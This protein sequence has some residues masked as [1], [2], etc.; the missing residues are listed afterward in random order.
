MSEDKFQKETYQTIV[1]TAQKLFMELGYRSVSTRQIAQTC[2]I[3]QPAL[4]HHFKNK[5][6]LY[7]AVLKHTLLET[8]MGLRAILSQYHSFYDR[9]CHISIYMMLQFEVDM[10]QMFHDINHELSLDEQKEIHQYWKNGFLM[11]VVNMIQ[12]GMENGEIKDSSIIGSSPI[13]LAFLI[14]NIIKSV[15]QAPNFSKLPPEE[16]RKT[17]EKNAQLIVEIF[18]NGMKA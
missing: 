8:E 16:Q 2:G 7:I 10:A 3:T 5:Q 6:T 9:F 14:L 4:Y 15:L 18:L 13:E 11:P 17:A 12:Q 1:I